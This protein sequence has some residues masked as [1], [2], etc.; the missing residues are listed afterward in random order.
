MAN[1][2]IWKMNFKKYIDQKFEK[3][4]GTTKNDQSRGMGNIGHTEQTVLNKR[5]RKPK[6][7]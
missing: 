4:E 7:Q 5:Q 2:C 1:A 6:E 3:T